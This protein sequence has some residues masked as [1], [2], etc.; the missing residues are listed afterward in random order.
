[1][2]LCCGEA[3][4]D[5]VRGTARGGAACFFPCPGGS[6][7]NTAIAMGRLGAPVQFLGKLSV[8]FL[9]DMLVNRLVRNR[10]GIDFVTRSDRHST[11]AFVNIAEDTEPQYIFYTEGTADRSLSIQDIP[12]APPSETDCILFGSIAM[13]MEPIASAVESLIFTQR[14]R[15]NSGPVISCD[16]NIR[17]FMIGDKDAYIGR[18]ETWLAASTIV[19]ISAADL[20]FIYPGLEPEE[21]L[22][23]ILALGPRLAVVTL[24][25][26]GAAA[27]LRREGGDFIRAEAPAVNLPVVDTIGAGDTFH[28]A[29]LSWL[30]LEGNLSRA[31]LASLSGRDLYEALYFANKAASLVCSRQGA[32]P[33]YMDEVRALHA[34]AG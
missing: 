28:G 25:A 6:P 29:F 33:P 10:V 13:T 27:L 8:D 2:I 30:E 15:G 32:E 1:M 19:K 24:G 26:K 21:S 14:N 11:L 5:M 23:K 20:S 9:G 17:P 22:Q 4:I 3:L 16:P 7:Y 12:A 18:L 31:A 34:P